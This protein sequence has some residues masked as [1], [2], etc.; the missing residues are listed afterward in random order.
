MLTT[1]GRINITEKMKGVNFVEKN[2]EYEPARLE[3]IL[4]DSG[5]IVTTSYALGEGDG[6]SWD[7]NGWT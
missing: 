6:D 1:A 4:F 3:L 5:D 2:R 7:N